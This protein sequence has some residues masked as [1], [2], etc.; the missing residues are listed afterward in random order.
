MT[1][2]IGDQEYEDAKRLARSDDVNARR[3]LAM[4]DD[5][6]PEILYFLAEDKAP[7]V[8]RAIASNDAT[9]YQ[10]DELLARDR[11]E[12]VRAELAQKVARLLPGLSADAKDEA[13]QRVIAMLEK[14]AK[15]EAVRVRAV[16]SEAVRNVTNVPPEVIQKLARDAELIVASPVLRFSPLLTDDD[17]L[18]IINSG[19][20]SGALAAIAQRQ[21][22][23]AKVSDAIVA[24]DDEPAVAALLANKSAQIREETLDL[25]ADRAANRAAWHEPLVRRPSLPARAAKRIAGFVAESL[26]S[27]LKNRQYLPRETREQ[28][29]AAVAERLATEKPAAKP[30]AAVEEKEEGESVE[31]K[32]T[33]LKKEGKLDEDAVDEALH[34]GQRAFVRAA[35]ALLAEVPV[36]V[37]DKILSA[38]SAKGVVALV[39]KAGL[40]MRLAVQVQTRLGGISPR[41]AL[42][43]R[44]G[45]AFPLTKEEMAWQIE[46]FGG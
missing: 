11:D 21:D 25:I 31:E 17:L 12:A 5:M 13:H 40:P 37:V 32:V 10:A 1:A 43:A 44:G 4:R 22:V 36:D 19:P 15:D 30:A 35:L 26:H 45:T 29:T 3:K 23:R 20:A 7:E 18:D 46:F 24:A 27:V 9:P 38:R 2:Q 28:V 34:A 16:V 6:R 14:L 8:R 33:R 42:Q 39:W 41:Q